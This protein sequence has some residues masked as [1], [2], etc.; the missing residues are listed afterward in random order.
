[1]TDGP[2]TPGEAIRAEMESRGWSQRDLAKIMGRPLPAI[3]E[4]IRGKRAITPEMAVS[5]SSAFGKDAHYWMNLE[6][7]FRLS[8]IERD[9]DTA[10][11]AKL[12]EV[13]PVKDLEAR[14]WIKRT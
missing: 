5:L 12:F 2:K 11:R 8:Q 4:I 7:S 10:R 1:M 3:N 6:V 9:N 13:A 14:G